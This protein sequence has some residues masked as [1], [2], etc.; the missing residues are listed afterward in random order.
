M[1]HPETLVTGRRRRFAFAGRWR[2][3][4]LELRM[5]LRCHLLFCIFLPLFLVA[6]GRSPRAY[7]ERGNSF[8]E[9]GNYAEAILN[10]QK[11]LQR[12]ARFAEA[13][14]RLGLA[15]LKQRD[16]KAALDSLTQAVELDPDNR[17]AREQL[18]DLL[19]TAYLQNRDHPQYLYDRLEALAARFLKEAPDSFQGHRILGFLRMTDR[20]NNE[21]IEEFQKALAAKPWDPEVT[22]ALL[23]PMLQSGRHAEAENLALATIER[24]KAFGPLYDVLYL[25]YLALGRQDDAEQLIR[26]KAADNPGNLEFA[27]QLAAHYYQWKKYDAMSDLLQRLLDDKRFPDSPLAVADFYAKR[28]NWAEATRI[29]EL[30]MARNPAKKET[31][32]KYLVLLLQGQGRQD[33]ALAMAEKLLQETPDDTA[34]LAAR[35][36]MLV[37][38]GG[39]NLEAA[40]NDY[41]KL[42][43]LEPSEPLF[44]FMLGRLH[45]LRGDTETA[46]NMYIEASR[47][48]SSYLPPLMGLAELSFER[49]DYKRTIEFAN[50]VLAFDSKN[51]DARVLLAA[52]HMGLGEYDL[53]RQVLSAVT[54]EFPSY[55]PAEVQLG[56]VYLNQKQF[57]QAD[58]LFRKHRKPGQ[59]DLRALRGLAESQLA[60]GKP[61]AALALVTEEVKQ[62]G[63]SV[64]SR[65]LLALIAVKANKPGAAIES[66]KPLVEADPNNA[67]RHARLADLYRMAGDADLAIAHF[68]KALELDSGETGSMVM[69]AALL[70]E[71]GRAEEAIGIYRKVLE[72]NPNDP[73]VLNNLALLL[74]DSDPE[75]AL[76]Y[77]Q[78]AL[79]QRQEDPSIRDTVGWIYAKTSR[80]DAAIQILDNLVREHPSNPT[81]RYHFGYALL[82]KGDRG[83]AKT[84]LE[85]A[86]AN[87]PS[88]QQ[89][90]E[91]RKLLGTLGA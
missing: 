19:L 74:A 72:R 11:A 37:R 49:G 40:M 31:Y 46:Q 32:E 17:D 16:P 28:G 71:K 75:K 68:R 88:K 44:R 38:K 15:Q 82:R 1:M 14:Y 56:Y 58:A 30:G 10:Y 76:E 6:C 50:R 77:A 5:R 36:Q 85:Q 51:P 55:A 61:D 81:Y 67:R 69:L 62:S 2:P 43:K 35:A 64:Q 57:S 80:L 54:R 12:D 45:H 23:K 13:H 79:Q 52:G 73:V 25:H 22:L 24:N 47:L 87:S 53:A 63:G 59:T 34:A 33:E 18:A 70:A 21:A 78:R 27:L 86:L 3:A 9:E 66:Y 29:T 65:E 90:A 91:I 42:V 84:Q 4:G 83:Q 7:L 41:R 26:R 8:F 39:A 20:R 48:R 89:E 60:Q